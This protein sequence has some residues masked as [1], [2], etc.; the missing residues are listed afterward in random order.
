MKFTVEQSI[1]YCRDVGQAH[2]ADQLQQ[3]LEENRRLKQRW[4]PVSEQLPPIYRDTKKTF[5]AAW[6]DDGDYDSIEWYSWDGV[7]GEYLNLNS[8][9]MNYLG[10]DLVSMFTHWQITPEPPCTE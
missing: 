2:I 9:N 7:E 4:I 3:L 10:D 8:N 6:M 5:L 1:Q